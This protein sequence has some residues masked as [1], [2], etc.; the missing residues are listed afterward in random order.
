MNRRTA[1]GQQFRGDRSVAVEHVADHP[2]DSE[3]SRRRSEIA[4]HAPELHRHGQFAVRFLPAAPTSRLRPGGIDRKYDFMPFPVPLRQRR[5]ELEHFA[6]GISQPQIER[7]DRLIRRQEHLSPE[8]RFGELRHLP[9]RIR[10][11]VEVRRLR[12]V[13]PIDRDTGSRGRN[14][15]DQRVVPPV[16]QQPGPVL[17]GRKEFDTLKRSGAGAPQYPGGQHDTDRKFHLIHLSGHQREVRS[18][19]I[20][21]LHR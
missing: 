21:H 18:H 11:T 17:S 4:G 6:V 9:R 14:A 2:P 10:L 8:I 19:K 5:A 15:A 12:R 3:R 1:P 13:R 20:G 7:T 16:K